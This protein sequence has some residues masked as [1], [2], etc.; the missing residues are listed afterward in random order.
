MMSASGGR[1]V[2]S[3]SLFA[4]RQT[5]ALWQPLHFGRGANVPPSNDGVEGDS[6]GLLTWPAVGYNRRGTGERHQRRQSA[7]EDDAADLPP[8]PLCPT[9]IGRAHV[10]NSSH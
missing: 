6:A 9:E 5:S 2:Q 3:V 1:D 10:L 7:S 4:P 8:I